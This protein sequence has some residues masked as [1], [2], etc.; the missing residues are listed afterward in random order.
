MEWLAGLQHRG[1]TKRMI[2][3]SVEVSSS[4]ARLTAGIRAES[5]EE[6]VRVATASHPGCEVRVLFPIDPEVFFAE[7]PVQWWGRSVV[8]PEA[9]ELEAA[10]SEPN[11]IAWTREVRTAG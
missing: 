4:S 1:A 2:S 3:V 6:A 7:D 10:G 9:T 5:I 8:L 11:L